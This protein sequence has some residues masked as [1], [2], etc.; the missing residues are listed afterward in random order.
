MI[1]TAATACN[2][3]L[4][5]GPLLRHTRAWLILNITLEARHR[6]TVSVYSSALTVECVCVE[7]YP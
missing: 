1:A 4:I 7:H 3:R 5:V 6:T 2:L